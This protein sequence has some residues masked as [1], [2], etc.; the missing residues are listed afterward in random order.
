M[1][2]IHLYPLPL[3]KS[4]HTN[5]CFLYFDKTSNT[6]Q[7]ISF[8]CKLKCKI[9]TDI[10]IQGKKCRILKWQ[11]LWRMTFYREAHLQPMLHWHLDMPSL[12]HILCG[13]SGSISEGLQH[14]STT[15]VEW[16]IVPSLLPCILI[17]I[18]SFSVLIVP[19]L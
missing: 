14:L 18:V 16:V 3:S 2:F 15:F 11:L 5:I 17:I 12:M 8:Y 4:L 9:F 7:A 6:P 13:L 19:A 1:F 10:R